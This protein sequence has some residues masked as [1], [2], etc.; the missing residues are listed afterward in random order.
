MATVAFEIAEA[1]ARIALPR[2]EL[3]LLGG[4]RGVLAIALFGAPLVFGA[5]ERWGWA[6]VVV[7]I[8]FALGLWAVTWLRRDPIVLVWSPFYAPGLLFLVLGS[9][10]FLTDRT[11]DLE[12][13][14]NSIIELAAILIAFFLALQLSRNKDA[15][16]W[17]RFGSAT[18]GYSFVVALFAVIQYFSSP[19]KLYWVITPRWRSWIFGPY[20]NHNHYAGLMEMLIPISACYSL[21]RY[22]QNRSGGLLAFG[23]LFA[24][25]SVLLSGSR[26][27][28]VALLLE[29]VVLIGI[30]LRTD[31]RAHAM[32]PAIWLTAALAVA[33]AAFLW[34]DNDDI[35]Q[36]LA[37]VFEPSQASDVSFAYRRQTWLDSLRM[38]RDHKG[39]GTGLGSFEYA[40]PRYQSLPGDDV[41][42]HAH[43]DYV[44]MLAETGIAGGA[45]VL[46]AMLLWFRLAFQNL[47]ERLRH[48]Y[49]WIQLGA[50]I[51]CCGLLF[52][53]LFDFNL[54]MP[55]NALWFAVCAALATAEV[56]RQRLLSSTS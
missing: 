25:A 44:E 45:L 40:F 29:A 9:F 18:V 23:V 20:L 56:P 21:S 32:R 26:G 47:R 35:A 22:R 36:H 28:M 50:A 39:L 49:G 55:A 17:R 41:W 13:T 51:G 37:T 52:H 12:S 46:T 27:G 33:F 2:D 53:S 3:R 1:D 7:L 10:Q 48:A 30:V 31:H 6:A 8:A 15:K 11:A 19:E 5:A 24:V 14:R 16:F 42:D 4:A 54:H 43:N 34:M 38:F